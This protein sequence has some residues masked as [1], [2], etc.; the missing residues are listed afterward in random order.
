MYYQGKKSSVDSPPG[1]P[2]F[3][4]RDFILVL[5]RQP[6]C[7]GRVGG[8]KERVFPG[9][10][11]WNPLFVFLFVRHD[12][13]QCT[14]HTDHWPYSQNLSENL[15]ERWEDATFLSKI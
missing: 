8:S 1:V 6:A 13:E 15:S 10:E 9:Q 3:G 5:G 11:K 2:A 4:Q 12:Y 7:E 14:A